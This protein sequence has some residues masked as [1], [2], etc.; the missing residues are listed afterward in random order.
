[1][2]GIKTRGSNLTHKQHPKPPWLRVKIPHG[3]TCREI[4]QLVRAKKL[5]T[6]CE[7]ALCPNMSECWSHGEATFMILGNACTRNCRFCAVSTKTPMPP[8][9]SEPG[10]VAEAVAF[11]KL[12]HAVITSVTRDDLND[13]GTSHF[14]ET[15]R[16][17]RR[18]NPET[19]IEV[20]I[21]DFKGES[22]ALEIV[23]DAEP[24]VLAHNMETVA[25]LYPGVRPQADYQRSLDLL[26]NAKTAPGILTKSG[27]MVGLG[28]SMDEIEQTLSDLRQA[29]CD[30][31]T[32]GQYLRPTRDHL[33][34]TRYYTPQEFKEIEML[35]YE[36]GFGRVASGP[37]VR[38]S[39]R[40]G[41]DL[42][43]LLESNNPK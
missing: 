4:L 41:K 17:I 43:E 7:S 20:L 38:S 36:L 30:M 26:K 14:A 10:E 1:M 31:L 3:S 28:E 13:G 21:P 27:I 18:K 16:H 8:D 24:E 19:T 9:P 6:V 12:T 22:R 35:A 23:L 33:P 37:L 11:M 29:D 2:Q 42:R 15:I 34:V 5:H 39:Y 32:I 25:R 40:A